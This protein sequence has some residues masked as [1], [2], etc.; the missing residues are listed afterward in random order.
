ML[1][2]WMMAWMAQEGHPCA[3]CHAKIVKDYAR[4]AMA[5]TSARGQS[6]K[7]AEFHD[8]ST[9]VKYSV[10]E[11][12]RMHFEKG[13]DV[14]GARQL[15]WI[16][17]S[18]R[19]GHSYLFREGARLYQAPLS[20][21]AGTGKWGL[22]PG[23]QRA[24]RLDLTRVIEPGCLNC[25]VSGEREGITCE[26]CHGEAEMHR[27][28]AG[29]A[30]VVN[31]SKLAT[32]ERDSICAQCH[33]TGAA[34]VAKYRADGKVWKPGEKLSDYSAVY[35]AA[36][37]QGDGMV[38]VTSHFEKL[39]L[40]QCQVKS[41]TRMSCTTC[42][43]PHREPEEASAFFNAK[44][45]ACHENKPCPEAPKGNCIGC[46]MPKAAGRGVDHSSYTDHSIPRRPGIAREARRGAFDA[47]W[48][49]RDS[50]RDQGV[51]LA[52][53][54][55]FEQARALLEDAVGKTPGDVVAMSQLAQIHERGGRQAEAAALYE[56]IL[57]REP[58]HVTA[59][60][61]LGVERVKKGRV[62][63]A[64]AMWRRALVGNPV[65]TGVRMNLAQGLMRLGRRAEAVAEV[66]EA[67]RLDPDQPRARALLRQ[68]KMN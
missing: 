46:H 48:P 12:L 19:V 28:S 23:F 58:G 52:V 18:G 65:Q 57:A 55:R 16:L 37:E 3:P 14:Q 1:F 44:C 50:A 20:W 66:E 39:S 60:V 51:A 17:G 7:P 8:S 15:D 36:G 41:G 11:A 45:D 67:L 47:F 43:D 63:E 4:T 32:E 62:E 25:H 54:Q 30:P 31:P 10:D 59:L 26:R 21:Y 53:L 68:L 38:G 5:R 24:G 56:K 22:S 64:I 34:R 42:H 13:S 6:A 40:S 49:G 33:L 9:G 29:K 2:V 35:L 27:R 61:N